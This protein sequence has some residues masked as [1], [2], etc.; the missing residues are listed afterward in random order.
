[1]MVFGFLWFSFWFSFGP[2]DEFKCDWLRLVL[3]CSSIAVRF[4]DRMEIDLYYDKSCCVLLC[5]HFVSGTISHI[6][7]PMSNSTIFF[8]FLFYHSW[9]FHLYGKRWISFS[10]VRSVDFI[11]CLG[12]LSIFAMAPKFEHCVCRPDFVSLD[13]AANHFTFLR[14]FSL[15][16]IVTQVRYPILLLHSVNQSIAKFTSYKFKLLEVLLF[17][18]R[19]LLEILTLILALTNSFVVRMW[20]AICL[21][22]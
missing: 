13:F 16:V 3:A 10:L 11:N 8:L 5:L 17:V 12:L 19:A 1:M 15:S 4:G 21:F 6:R 7:Y 14:F 2:A 18:A 9:N 20:C 22:I